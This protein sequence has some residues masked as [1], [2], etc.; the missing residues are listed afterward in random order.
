M[1]PRQVPLYPRREWAAHKRGQ[2]S[3]GVGE[4]L[5]NTAERKNDAKQMNTNHGW[6]RRRTWQLLPR[7]TGHDGQILRVIARRRL[8]VRREPNGRLASWRV[9]GGAAPPAR[10]LFAGFAPPGQLDT[11]QKVLALSL[12]EALLVDAMPMGHKPPFFSKSTFFPN[13]ALA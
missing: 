8:H 13:Q 12:L 5:K 2:G 4:V 9:H 7:D 11:P 1:L 6:C 3:Q 10:H